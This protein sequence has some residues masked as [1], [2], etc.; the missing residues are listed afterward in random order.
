MGSSERRSDHEETEVRSEDPAAG[1]RVSPASSVTSLEATY[2]TSAASRLTGNRTGLPPKDS[3]LP[4]V[5][6]RVCTN[7]QSSQGWAMTSILAV[8]LMD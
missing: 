2:F 4:S 8:P 7:R 5:R 1:R 6:H 3:P